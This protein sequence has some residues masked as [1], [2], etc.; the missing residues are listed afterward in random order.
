MREP[1]VPQTV[2]AEYGGKW[3]VWTKDVLRIVGV[4]DTPPRNCIER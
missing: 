2:P 4:G 3:V 1:K